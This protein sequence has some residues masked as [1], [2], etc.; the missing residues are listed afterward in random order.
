MPAVST[1]QELRARY[2]AGE[3]DFAGS[4]LDEDPDYDLDGMCLDGIDLSRSWVVA[5]FRG[6]SLRNATFRS[7]NIKTCDFTE[8]D[9][10]GAD[11]SGAGLCAATFTGAKMENARFAG[12]SY[13]SYE[14]KAGELPDF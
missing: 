13:H 9:L 5:S 2:Q 7:A 10:S 14:F 1:F 8:A 6:V 4:E 3:R 12:A 11:F